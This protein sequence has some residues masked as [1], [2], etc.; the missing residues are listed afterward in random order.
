MAELRRALVTVAV[1]TALVAGVGPSVAGAAEGPERTR[2]EIGTSVR[3]RPITVVHRAWPGATTKV[4]VIGNI[5]GD[6]L[7]GLRVVRR[8]RERRTLPRNLDLY[9]VRTA[10]PDG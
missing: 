3:G 1:A 10:N 8:L 5:H 7:A 9:L 4:V 2:F 6:E